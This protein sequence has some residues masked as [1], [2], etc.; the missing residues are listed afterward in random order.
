MSSELWGKSMVEIIHKQ[1]EEILKLENAIKSMKSEIEYVLNSNK[2]DDVKS[3]YLENAVRYAED[4]IC[5]K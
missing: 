2:T 1:K 4:V 3:F 5:I